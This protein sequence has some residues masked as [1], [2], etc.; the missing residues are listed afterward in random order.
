MLFYMTNVESKEKPTDAVSSS[1]LFGNF[2]DLVYYLEISN[3]L[4]GKIQKFHKFI[5]YTK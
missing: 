2:L 4:V 5:L 1:S 3:N